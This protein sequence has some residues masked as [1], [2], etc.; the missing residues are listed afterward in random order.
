MA[1]KI[2]ALSMAQK[3]LGSLR[4]AVRESVEQEGMRPFANRLGVPLGQ[5]RGLL[6]DRDV[7]ASTVAFLA[8]SMGMELYVGPAKMTDKDAAKALAT[9]KA[10]R[11]EME[12]YRERLEERL[13]EVVKLTLETSDFFA[14]TG[15]AVPKGKKAASA[16]ENK[17]AELLALF[18]G[19]EGAKAQDVFLE[20]CKVLAEKSTKKA[21][22][23]KQKGSMEIF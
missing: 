15:T 12:A 23:R 10:Q 2:E 16:R 5:L 17:R 1:Q 11:A 13:S 8:D 22:T 19:I 3:A 4:D 20:S 9:W 21:G 14:P 7:Q 6:D 18:D